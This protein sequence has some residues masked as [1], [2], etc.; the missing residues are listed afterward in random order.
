MQAALRAEELGFNVTLAEA[1]AALGGQITLSAAIPAREGFQQI[2]D[3][4][5]AAL[6]RSRVQV[7]LG[8]RYGAG[9]PAFAAYDGLIIAT[10]ASPAPLRETTAI[11]VPRFPAEE[12]V[13]NPALAS[14]TR[15]LLIIDEGLTAGPGAAELLAARG[16]EV[17]IVLAGSELGNALPY[18]N[19][20]MLMD[21]LLA[22]PQ[23]HWH[24][25]S[26]LQGI[27]QSGKATLTT[28]GKGEITLDA[29]FDFVVQTV[30]R[31]ANSEL[32]D[33]LESAGNIEFAAAGD[34]VSPRN[35]Y[36]AIREG[37]D[38]ADRVAAALTSK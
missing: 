19:R 22:M 13:Q 12:I 16:V 1:G 33:A 18:T 7:L 21:R 2:S 20:R 17:H 37:F 9:A 6:A 25:H 38:A 24:F 26:T 27:D 34:C 3:L 8:Q 29:P 10:G 32:I 30:Q 4:L 15:A 11:A 5:R 31:S 28:R 35:I 36:Y 14:G 23:L